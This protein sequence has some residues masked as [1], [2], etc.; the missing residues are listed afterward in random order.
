MEMKPTMVQPGQPLDAAFETLADKRP[1]ASSFRESRPRGGRRSRRGASSRYF[2][3]ISSWRCK[4]VWWLTPPVRVALHRRAVDYVDRILKGT[5]PADLP[6]QL[7]TP[8]RSRRR[9]D[10]SQGARLDVPRRPRPRRR[11]I[12][13][14]T[15]R[16]HH[17][18]RQ[19]G[20]RLATRGAWAACGNPCD[21]IPSKHCG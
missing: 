21:R 17:A 1:D 4:A 2:R 11:G 16:V 13:D 8:V 19:R 7:P 18:V 6:V 3:P 14:E 9:S 10:G 5:K 15:P 12:D 20:G